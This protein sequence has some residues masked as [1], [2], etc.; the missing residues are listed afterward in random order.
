MGPER[1]PTST[2][3]ISVTV[4]RKISSETKNTPFERKDREFRIS[5]RISI[6]NTCRRAE[7]SWKGSTKLGRSLDTDKTVRETTQRHATVTLMFID[8]AS[9]NDDSRFKAN[10]H[11]EL[12]G[13]P[14]GEGDR[15]FEASYPQFKA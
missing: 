5:A 8:T 15:V 7:W 12:S 11:V 2:V 9:S 14:Q 3:E 13:L 6:S 1:S 4:E 10:I